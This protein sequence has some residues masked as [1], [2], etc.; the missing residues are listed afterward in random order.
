LFS[1]FP[2]LRGEGIKGRV[3]NFPSALHPHLYPPPSY[4]EEKRIPLP[5]RGEGQ[6][7]GENFS[8]TLTLHPHL[9]P[10]PSYGEELNPL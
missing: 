5:L 9:Y 2:S 10:P 3:R 4:G 6:G 7:E 1:C 8:Y